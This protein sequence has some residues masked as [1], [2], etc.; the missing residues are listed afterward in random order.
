VNGRVEAPDAASRSDLESRLRR[1]RSA[2]ERLANTVAR[3]EQIVGRS[4]EIAAGRLPNDQVSSRHG[5][6]PLSEVARITGR[7]PDLLRRWCLDGRLE[8]VRIGRTWCLPERMLDELGRFQRRSAG[9]PKAERRE[10]GTRAEV[11]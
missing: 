2:S 11:R 8:A 5:L 7:H 6:L 4:A 10:P 1:L 3:T 9:R